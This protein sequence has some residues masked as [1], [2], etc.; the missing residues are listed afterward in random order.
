M[1][2][3]R[4]TNNPPTPTPRRGAD[5]EPLWNPLFTVSPS[6][7]IK[8]HVNCAPDVLGISEA[9]VP[10]NYREGP[11]PTQITSGLMVKPSWRVPSSSPILCVCVL[12]PQS[13]PALCGPVD[14]SPP[15]SSV[16]GILQATI[17]E[18]VATGNCTNGNQEKEATSPLHKSSFKQEH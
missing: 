16:H 11:D 2:S 5:M 3:L 4:S 14:C 15:G 17:L 6:A 12:V 13:C 1:E 8:H 10:P 7:V 9:P 18:W